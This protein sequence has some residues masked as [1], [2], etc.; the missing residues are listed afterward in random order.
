MA[1]PRLVL[2]PD[3]LTYERRAFRI[4]FDDRR[5]ASLFMA[6]ASLISMLY[7]FLLPSLPSGT[8]AFYLIRFITPIQIAFALTFGVLM[9]LVIILDIHI[10]RIHASSTRKFTVGA[11]LASLVNSLCCT[12]LVPTLVALSGVSPLL[13][14]RFSPAIQ[15][16]FGHN[17]LYFYLLSALSLFVSIH[18]LGKSISFC[19]RGEA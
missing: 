17:Y 2:V 15:A 3:Y 9:S 8:V 10:F 13:L 14:F 16:F 19:T 7:M 6:L 11:I 12:P 5:Y 1:K 4:I 18:Y